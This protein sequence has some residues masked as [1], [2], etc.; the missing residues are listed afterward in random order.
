MCTPC[1]FFTEEGFH[2]ACDEPLDRFFARFIYNRNFLLENKLQFPPL[3]VY[4]DPIF[5][6]CTLFKSQRIL[7]R[8]RRGLP[9]NGTHSNKRI[10]LACT[11]DYLRGL[12]AELKLSKKKKTCRK[13]TRCAATA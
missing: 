5:L 7:R 3:R 2:N 8:A 13:F 10:T 12:I 9:L 6:L 11:K 1:L 4:E